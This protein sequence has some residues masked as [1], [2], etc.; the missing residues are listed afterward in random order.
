MKVLRVAFDGLLFSDKKIGIVNYIHY[1]ILELLKRDDP[2]FLVDVYVDE[3]YTDHFVGNAK[4]VRIIPVKIWSRTHRLFRQYTLGRVLK[5]TYHLF[6]S[7]DYPLPLFL[8]RRTKSIVVIPDVSI[9]NNRSDFIFLRYLAKKIGYRWAV[10]RADAIVTYSK[11]VAD[12]L[13]TCYPS[14]RSKT[15]TPIW[16]GRSPQFENSELRTKSYLDEVKRKY[17]LPDAYFLFVGTIMP[18]KNLL[19]VLKAFEAVH[20]HIALDLIVVGARGWKYD[21]IFA[22]L[23][24][25]SIKKRVHFL[26]YVNDEDLPALYA[27]AQFL[28]F[29][30]FEEGFGIPIVEAFSVGCPVITSNCSSMIE[31][32][33]GHSILVDPRNCQELSNALVRLCNDPLELERQKK[34]STAGGMKFSWQT[35]ASQTLQLIRSLCGTSDPSGERLHTLA[36]KE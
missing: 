8:S 22:F 6:F 13:L 2:S 28:V 25:A 21:N 29:P 16:L 3:K 7:P 31:I 27:Q 10:S 20:E 34:L 18:R 5:G 14:L 1:L 36:K 30:S 26:G 33:Q 9:H 35:T 24:R 19:G 11:A 23:E 17:H 15:I 12:N 4:N 32:A